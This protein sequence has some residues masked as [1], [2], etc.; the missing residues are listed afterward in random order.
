MATRMVKCYHVVSRP[1]SSTKQT[2]NFK[3]FKQVSVFCFLLRHTVHMPL[4]LNRWGKHQNKQQNAWQAEVIRIKIDRVRVPTSVVEGR[5]KERNGE[6]LQHVL[7]RV[8]RGQRTVFSKLVK[9][10][11][12]ILC[13]PPVSTECCAHNGSNGGQMKAVSVWSCGPWTFYKL[14]L[15]P[16]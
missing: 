1:Y 2:L 9:P 13:L 16:D 5:R 11:M 15:I 6:C 12:L 10:R 4:C 14:I 8:F 3:H 7:A